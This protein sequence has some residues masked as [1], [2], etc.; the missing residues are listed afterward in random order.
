[1]VCIKCYEKLE[2]C[3]VSEV[4]SDDDCFLT[5]HFSH[6]ATIRSRRYQQLQLFCDFE[7][8]VNTFQAAAVRH[9]ATSPGQ[10]QPELFI[11]DPL[12]QHCPLIGGEDLLLCCDWS[13]CSSTSQDAVLGNVSRK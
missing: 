1:M 10:V 5:I 3:E 13:D 11:I 12:R 6:E 4:E 8:V 2:S 9:L 7:S